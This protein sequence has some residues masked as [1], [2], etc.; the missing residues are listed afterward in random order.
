MK[1]GS[2]VG[3][4]LPPQWLAHRFDETRNE[5]RFVDHDRATRSSVPFLTDDYLP[6]APYRAEP[7]A[8]ALQLAPASAPI[9][10]VF[11]SGFCCSTLFASCFDQPGLAT[12]FSEPMILNDVVGWRK[13]GASPADVGRL[14]E[15]ALTLLARPFPGDRAALVKP[16]TVVNGL[17]AAMMNVRP[18]ARAIVMHAPLDDFLTSIA[19]KGIDGRLWVRELFL[20]MRRESLVEGLGF[21]DAEFFGQ[22]DLQIAAVAWLAQQRLFHQ[23]VT[24]FPERVRSLDGSRFLDQP[25]GS[26]EAA[27]KFLG[28]A[29]SPDQLSTAEAERLS[30]NSKDG[31]PYSKGARQAE[32]RAA[33]A[34]HGD[35][36]GK[37]ATWAR[38]VASAASVPLE[39]G[40]PLT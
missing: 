32:Y 39:P 7:R 19:K 30:R 14:L 31:K 9:H 22:T 3:E 21:G 18:E 16:S 13:R 26:L 17:A 5:I 20:A 34:A 12:T 23:L 25:R 29:L 40:N 37:V 15:D 1:L 11:H 2:E 28:L 8:R 27:G 38:A 10:F 6:S 24:R 35:E 36:I 4:S 33:S